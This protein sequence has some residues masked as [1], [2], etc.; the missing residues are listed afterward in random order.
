MRCLHTRTASRTQDLGRLAS[1]E[2]HASDRADND[3]RRIPSAEILRE[4]SDSRRTVYDVL[5]TFFRHDD[6]SIELGRGHV[7]RH[8]YLTDELFQ[9]LW[10]CMCAER[11][12]LI[13]VYRL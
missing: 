13:S 12:G 10:K 2:G 8:Q 6:V 3:F 1:Y 4:L 5:P 11:T 7:R 9:L